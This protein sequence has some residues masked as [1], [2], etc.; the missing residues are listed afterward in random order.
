[1]TVRPFFGL[2]K[3]RDNPYW[4]LA[5]LLVIIISAFYTQRLGQTGRQ[6]SGESSASSSL[7]I[8]GSSEWSE[9]L[10]RKSTEFRDFAMVFCGVE[11]LGGRGCR[12]VQGPKLHV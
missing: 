8:E 6:L 7:R 11:G 1:M 4:N 5:P 9:Q 3:F 12:E 2:M 10:C